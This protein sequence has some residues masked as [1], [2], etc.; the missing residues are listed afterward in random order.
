MGYIAP[1][2]FD[3]YTQYANRLAN[4]RYDYARLTSSSAG[5]LQSNYIEEE[6]KHEQRRFSKILNAVSYNKEVHHDINQLTGKGTL[7]NEYV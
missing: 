3:T 7:F 2:Q 4:K 5:Q 6:K 1:I